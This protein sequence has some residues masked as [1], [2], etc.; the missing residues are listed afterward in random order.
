MHGKKTHTHTHSPLSH[1]WVCSCFFPLVLKLTCT[2]TWWGSPASPG[3]GRWWGWWSS[4]PGC[5]H[6]H[7]LGGHKMQPK[8]GSRTWH[9][10]AEMDMLYFQQIILTVQSSLYQQW[11]WCNALC[12]ESETAY[13]RQSSHNDHQPSSGCCLILNALPIFLL[14]RA[15]L[16]RVTMAIVSSYSIK[17]LLPCTIL[18]SLLTPFN[19]ILSLFRIILSHFWHLLF[20]FLYNFVFL[21]SVVTI[22]QSV[23]DLVTLQLLTKYML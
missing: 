21:L 10:K 2:S 11:C 17:A 13:Q 4:L 5:L 16:M 3:H 7:S 8:P 23:T 6:P 22:F 1:W 18:S 14:S 12:F 15:T 19:T 20:L 9:R